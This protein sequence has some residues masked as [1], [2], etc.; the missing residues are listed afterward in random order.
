MK[1]LP[2]VCLLTLCVLSPALYAQEAGRDTAAARRLEEYVRRYP[3]A[4]LRDVYKFCFQDVYGPG[5]LVS[6][7]AA[8][9]AYILGEIA[10]MDLSD[11]RYP[12]FEYV[13][14]ENNFVRVNLRVV[15]EGMVPLGQFVSL[16]MQS[17]A[18]PSPMPVAEW[19]ARWVRY[20]GLMA[21]MSARPHNF[22][23][24]SAA[25]LRQLERG[26]YVSHHSA[27]FNAAYAPHYRLIRRDLFEKQELFGIKN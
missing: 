13:G 12:D 20:M 19:R 14:V 3:E 1:R 6:D 26:E 25:I 5:H 8:C 4:Q 11:H 17:A 7:S 9:A 15:A 22:E 16:L 23:E 2:F 18:I 10:R 21:G 27:R 24:D